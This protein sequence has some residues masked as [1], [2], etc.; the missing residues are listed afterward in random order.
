MG[1]RISRWTNI[2]A[3]R[4]QRGE[5]SLCKHLNYSPKIFQRFP[6]ADKKKNEFLKYFRSARI[7]AVDEES[8]H[9]DSPPTNE[10]TN[11]RRRWGDGRREVPV[12]GASSDPQ[13]RNRSGE[14]ETE[15]ERGGSEEI[16]LLSW[17][18]VDL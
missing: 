18:D 3:G 6:S 17:L 4:E 12:R 8:M 5:R 13:H 14:R 7:S 1:E 16:L 10:R 15:R 11:E 2:S 9:L